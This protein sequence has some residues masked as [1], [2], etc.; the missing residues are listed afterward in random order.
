MNREEVRAHLRANVTRNVEKENEREIRV[1]SSNVLFGGWKNGI[2]EGLTYQER[3][4]ILTEYYLHYK[5]DF[6]GLQKMEP[7]IHA[8]IVKNLEDEYAI[9]PTDYYYG[10]PIQTPTMYRKADW[11]PLKTGIHR[12]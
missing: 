8:E 2:P 12:F 1:M 10:K 9:P 6:L 5:P 3:A 7:T 4:M 11:E